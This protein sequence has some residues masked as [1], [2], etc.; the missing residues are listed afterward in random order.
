[1]RGLRGQ[2]AGRQLLPAAERRLLPDF[3]GGREGRELGLLVVE[4]GI[5]VI[6]LQTITQQ[7]K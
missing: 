1:M 6:L 3:E 7:L 5:L 4:S 2:R